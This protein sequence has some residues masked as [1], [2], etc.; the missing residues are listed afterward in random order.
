MIGSFLA[1]QGFVCSYLP[2]DHGQNCRNRQ[3]MAYIHHV[4]AETQ[5]TKSI[6]MMLILVPMRHSLQRHDEAH[7]QHLPEQICKTQSLLLSENSYSYYCMHSISITNTNHI[8]QSMIRPQK[9]HTTSY[10]Y[11]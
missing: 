3:S 7:T 6:D 9:C 5:P 8:N 1:L 2:C 4:C 10:Y 11:Y